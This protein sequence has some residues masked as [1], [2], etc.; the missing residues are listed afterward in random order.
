MRIS[1]LVILTSLA[2]A[3][4]GEVPLQ[5]TTDGTSGTGTESS[6]GTETS[7]STSATPPTTGGDDDLCV[8]G[9]TV[10]C[11]CPN[12]NM[13]SQECNADGKSY[14]ACE[15]EGGGSNSN[16]DGTLEPTSTTTTGVTATTGETTTT[17]GETTTEGTT[18]TSTGGDDTT[19]GNGI[20]EDPGPEPNDAEDKAV[21]LGE[22]GCGAMAGTLE[23][24]L[25]SDGDAD[26][27]SYHGTWNALCIIG[28]N[29]AHSVTA[30]DDVRLCVFADCDQ[31]NGNF[32][33]GGGLSEADSPDGLPGCCGDGDVDFN[34]DCGL[35]NDNA[36]LY[37]RVDQAPAGAC[38]EYSVQYDFDE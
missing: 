34:L 36:R 10:P 6:S 31:G 25:D 33:C 30:S 4:C 24:V 22:Q 37:I 11:T 20:C 38:V 27:F 15:C 12:A 16:S 7:T 28:P 2:V 3:A 19:T 13:G 18:D 29:L 14:G 23:G 17:E 1:P 21:D 5:G 9:S 32:N 35:L 26:W 8:P